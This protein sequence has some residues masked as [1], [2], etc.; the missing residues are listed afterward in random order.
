MDEQH[1]N[2]Q[3]GGDINLGLIVT[4]GFVAVMLLIVLVIG[5]QAWFYHAHDA[6]FERKVVNTT[7]SEL[8]SQRD[9]Q[10]AKLNMYRY[11]D[12]EQGLVQIEIGEAIK[13]YVQRRAAQ[14]ET[15]PD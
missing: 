8:K 3:Q 10:V 4:C 11:V 2:Q 14:P 9:A 5:I 1:D 15:Q 6:E 13:R 12:Q 7:Y